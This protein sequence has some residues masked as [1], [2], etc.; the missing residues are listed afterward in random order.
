MWELPCSKPH[1][2]YIRMQTGVQCVSYMCD[3]AKSGDM[4]IL[5]NKLLTEIGG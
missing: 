5:R 1:E 2:T 4:K 3:R